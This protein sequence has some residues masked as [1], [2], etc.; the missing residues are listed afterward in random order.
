VTVQISIPQSIREKLSNARR[1]FR[2][3]TMRINEVSVVVVLLLIGTGL[4]GVL[5]G[6]PSDNPAALISIPASR[7]IGGA[8]ALVA[9]QPID[10]A[11]YVP[12]KEGPPDTRISTRVYI[13]QVERDAQGTAIAVIV[14]T[15]DIGSATRLRDALAPTDATVG[16]V[17]LAPSQA[18][19]TPGMPITVT[20]TISQTPTLTPTRT[21]TPTT[22]TVY[23]RIATER[24][25]PDSLA[26]L[27][28]DQP[29]GTRA[30]LIIVQPTPVIGPGTPMP[31]PSTPSAPVCVRVIAA[32]DKQGV[33]QSRIA[34]DPA[35]KALL[36]QL[37][38]KDVARVVAGLAA[39]PALWLVPDS[40]CTS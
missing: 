40:A 11:V 6:R 13:Q 14:G 17:A 30:Q 4:Y 10:L 37:P 31:M 23:L 2:E 29:A 1:R 32:L 8:S 12:A 33:W 38:S 7:L 28:I 19:V 15:Q 25:H 22:G 5:S 21:A 16:Y 34:A 27:T 35:P 3:V 36:I 39:G 9:G 26:L 20:S 18:A 24:I